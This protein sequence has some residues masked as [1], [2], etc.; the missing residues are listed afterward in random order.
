MTWYKK[1]KISS[2]FS[3]PEEDKQIMNEL[4][5][6]IITLESQYEG[7]QLQ[8]HLSSGG[9]ILIAE[10]KV[11]KELRGQG[12]GSSVIEEIKNF[13]Q[14]YNK[15]I[16]L[17]PQP[18]KGKKKALDRFYRNLDFIHNKGRKKRYDLSSPFG[19]TMYWSPE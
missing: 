12:I 11:P 8:A 6:L 5:D 1:I 19:P 13:A 18:E 10:I 4:N 16:V 3:L 2:I 15:E 9:Y 14:K 7:L 17:T